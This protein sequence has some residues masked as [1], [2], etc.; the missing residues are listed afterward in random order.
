MG[1]VSYFNSLETI[2]HSVRCFTSPSMQKMSTHDT[3]I[4]VL[5]FD[6]QERFSVTNQSID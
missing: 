4:P 3:S 5:D 2:I 6:Q 1:C